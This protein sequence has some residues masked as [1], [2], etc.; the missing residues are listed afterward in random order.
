[1]IE[2]GNKNKFLDI[3]LCEDTLTGGLI[4]GMEDIG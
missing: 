4:Y 3:I 1:M 2:Y